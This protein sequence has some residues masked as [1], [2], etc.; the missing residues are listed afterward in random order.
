MIPILEAAPVRLRPW[1]EGDIADLATLANSRAVWRNLRDRFPHPYGEDDARAWVDCCKTEVDDEWR[2]AIER[3]GRLCGGIGLRRGGDVARFSAELGYWL[4]E[5]HWGQGNA[6]AAVRAVV[7]W[8]FAC[9]DIRRVGARVMHWNP[10][11]AR[12]L[13]KAGFRAEG[14]TRLSSFKDGYFVDDLHFGCLRGDAEGK[15]MNRPAVE[16]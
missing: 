14:R 12:V 15:A 8:A 1:R 7:E 11:S 2:W 4:G 5:A 6:T 9:T 10:A 13:E 3:E 16:P